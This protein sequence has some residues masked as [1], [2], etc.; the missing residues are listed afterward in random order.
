MFLQS[1]QTG[2]V[3]QAPLGL[4]S[5]KENLI[6]LSSPQQIQIALTVEDVLGDVI[7]SPPFRIYFYCY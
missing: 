7:A 3:F 6:D 4:S 2:V 1:S 5:R